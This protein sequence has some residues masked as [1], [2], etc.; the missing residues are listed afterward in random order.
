MRKESEI[1]CNNIFRKPLVPT[2]GLVRYP[3]VKMS[4]CQ[5]IPMARDICTFAVLFSV[6]QHFFASLFCF[7]GV[8]EW[9]FMLCYEE[10]F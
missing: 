1:A 2:F 8:Y 10:E 4:L 9:H 5:S 6:S 3:K 7:S